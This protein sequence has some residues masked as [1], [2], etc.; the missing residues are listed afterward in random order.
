MIGSEEVD[1]SR[2]WLGWRLPDALGRVII[3][4]AVASI[5]VRVVGI[6]LSYSANVLLSRLLGIAE[7]GQYAIVLSWAMVLMLP[8][9]AGLDNSAL[10]YAT[11][12]REQGDFAALRGFIR[13]ATLLVVAISL[14]IVAIVITS[15]IEMALVGPLFVWAA[16]LALPLA[17][18][19]FF[20]VLM[21]TALRIVASQFYD[22]ILR[23]LLLIVG[24]IAVASTSLRLT[25]GVALAL[26]ALTAVGALA[27]LLVHFRRLFRRSRSERPDYGMWRQWLA[28][29]LPMLMVGVSQEL[30]NQIDIILLGLL[31]DE[32]QAALFAVSWRLASLVP[33]ALVGLATM[34]G[35]LIASAHERGSNDELHRVSRLVTRIGFLFAI[36]AA[37]ILLSAGEWLL[38]IFG[39]AF[40]AGYPVLAI[41]VVGGLVNAFTGVVAY[42][43][44]LT[45]RERHALV[46]FACALVLS[47]GLNL[48]LIPRFGA[49]GAA[50]AS[51]AATVAWNLA[52]LVYVRRAIGI[53]ASAMSLSPIGK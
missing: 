40:V 11:I 6:L 16:V 52:M 9:K 45:G 27:A 21:R 31:A 33:F 7:Y 44:L 8:A 53:D 50:V 46:V 49:I 51:S 25:A 13:F 37:A 41:L 48:F 3:G 26:T 35:P 28:I 19:A 4:G 24:L 32:R 23:P 47:L 42:L 22:Q 43:M 10:R 39:P 18:M 30:M 20:S 5:V 14:G 38:G 29:S 17:L 36:A 2:R 34:A 15:A 12:Y 1:G